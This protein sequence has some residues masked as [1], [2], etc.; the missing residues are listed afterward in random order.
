MKVFVFPVPCREASGGG[1]SLVIRHNKDQSLCN[2]LAC[3][4]NEA[5]EASVDS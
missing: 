1:G 4:V 2:N 5:S 3:D